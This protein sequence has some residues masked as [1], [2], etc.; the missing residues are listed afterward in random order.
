M[1]FTITYRDPR[2]AGF[3]GLSIVASELQAGAA[4]ERLR[5]EG[6]EI[7]ST[8]P[9]LARAPIERGAAPPV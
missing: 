6:Y 5:R 4:L 3:T 2:F 9:R 8:E 7:T 1:G